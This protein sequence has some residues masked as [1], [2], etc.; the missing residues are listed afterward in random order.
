MRCINNGV[1][2]PFRQ[3]A[4]HRVSEILML[5]V[6]IP[7]GVQRRAGCDRLS[8][9]TDRPKWIYPRRF[10][11]RINDRQPVTKTCSPYNTPLGPTTRIPL[12]GFLAGIDTWWRLHAYLA[13]VVERCHGKAQVVGSNPTVGSVPK[14]LAQRLL[15]A[16]AERIRTRMRRHE[17]Q[18]YTVAA[19][20]SKYTVHVV[21]VKWL[22]S[23]L[24]K[25][26]VRVRSS[27][28]ARGELQIP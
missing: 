19:R 22:S 14:A 16:N 25:F 18:E 24:A 3:L 12:Y 5:R 4:D 8:L 1:S 26:G 15:P 10:K 6:R 13:P 2:C 11:R 7:I 9:P 23:E 20:G 27:V 21:M 28:T 17:P